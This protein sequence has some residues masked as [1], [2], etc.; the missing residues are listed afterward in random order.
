[1]LLLRTP[2]LTRE[3]KDTTESVNR[4]VF[5]LCKSVCRGAV[6]N[7]CLYLQQLIGPA[8]GKMRVGGWSATAC[9][10]SI[11]ETEGV[12]I[13]QRHN[14]MSLRREMGFI[15]LAKFPCSVGRWRMKVMMRR[16]LLLPLQAW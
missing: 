7:I 16:S 11:M 15:Q 4:V 14:R 6:S 3:S 9:I 12:L 13:G 10:T 1:M 5:C 8:V 2:K